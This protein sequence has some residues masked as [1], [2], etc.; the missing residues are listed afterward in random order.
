MKHIN[1]KIPEPVIDVLNALEDAGFSAHIVG[2][3]LRD[4][5]L[6][7]NPKDWD[8]ATEAK[9][10]EITPLFPKT[11]YENSFGTVTVVNEEIET[12]NLK[13]IQVTTFRTEKDY[14]DHRHPDTVKFVPSI[15]EDIARRDFTINAM[16]Y[17]KYNGQLIDLYNGQKDIKDKRIR[18]V[19]SAKERLSEDPLRILRA[20]RL[21]CELDFFIDNDTEKE[22]VTQANSLNHISVERIRD[23]FTKTIN[24]PQPAKG[25][26]LYLKLGILKHVIPELEPAEG[27]EQNGDHKFDLW[28]HTCRAL[29]HSADRD[30]PLHVRLAALFHDIGKLKTRRWSKEKNDWTFYG[31]D[32]VGAKIT[33]NIMNRMKFPAKTTTTVVKLVRNHMFFTDIDKITL[34]AVRRIIANVGPEN[35]WDLMKLRTCDRIGMGRPKENPYRLRK[36]EA[37]IEEAM[38]APTSVGML[39]ID[40]ADIMKNTNEAPGPRIGHILHAVLEETLENPDLNNREYLLTRIQELHLLSTEELK[41]LGDRGKTKKDQTEKE[42]LK[43]IRKKY[44]VK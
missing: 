5:M 36:Y 37:M 43:K 40:G 3:C 22:I 16:S 26:M 13:H 7:L 44:G 39:K 38:R 17:R 30:M 27:F 35:V 24:S 32:V 28:E 12:E 8:V 2:G 29:D 11:V 18:T 15:E 25:M 20:V 23:E 9:P 6:G 4:I 10:E 34:S 31:H 42:E 1:S 19:G 14:T 41:K 21:A 33:K